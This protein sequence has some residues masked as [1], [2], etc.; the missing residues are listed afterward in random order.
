MNEQTREETAHHEAGH[1]VAAVR[2]GFSCDVSIR[3]DL[4]SGTLGHSVPMVHP[5][6]REDYERYVVLLCAGYAAGFRYAPDK[7]AIAWAG[8]GSDFEA[9]EKAGRRHPAHS[10]E[11]VFYEDDV[12]EVCAQTPARPP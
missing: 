3:P 4:D 1:A 6:S 5:E 7:K 9:S 10:V 12:G 11:A 2:F 8:A